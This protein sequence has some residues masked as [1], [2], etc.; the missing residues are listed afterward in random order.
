MRKQNVKMVEIR[1]RA[2]C[3][4][5]LAILMIPES[6]DEVHLMKQT[7][8]VFSHP[9]VMLISIEAPWHSA[10]T[11]DEWRNSPRTMPTAHKFIEENFHD[12]KD[13][14]VVDVEFLLGEVSEPCKSCRQEKEDELMKILRE[15]ATDE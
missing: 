10:R 12:I 2:T 4:P 14:Q 13:C 5:A 9:C 7:G 3:I 15:Q 1:D 6:Q 8:Y 11:W